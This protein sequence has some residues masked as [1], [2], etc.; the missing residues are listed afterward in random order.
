MLGRHWMSLRSKKL[1]RGMNQRCLGVT[2]ERGAKQC[3]R[4]GDKINTH[5]PVFH[6]IDP[7][8]GGCEASTLVGLRNTTAATS[9][10]H[11]R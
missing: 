1:E 3:Y 6:N 7:T 9:D 8:V 4:R 5:A 10:M 11:P 2:G